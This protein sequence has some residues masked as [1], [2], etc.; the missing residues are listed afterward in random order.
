MRD[1][2]NLVIDGDA[3][4]VTRE[5]DGGLQTIKLKAPAP[6]ALIELSTINPKI[7]YPEKFR[8]YSALVAAHELGHAL[9][10]AQDYFPLRFRS[11]I[12]PA[13]SADTTATMS[14]ITSR[15]DI[16]PR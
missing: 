3:I 15:R 13:V 2:A 9:Q 11:A 12:V 6:P 7:G 5:V 10:D 4:L 14:A 1:G 16:V 8:D